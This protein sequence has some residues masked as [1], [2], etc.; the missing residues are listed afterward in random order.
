MTREEETEVLALRFQELRRGELGKA[1][2]V[3]TVVLLFATGTIVPGST[4]PM[5]A[6]RV[7]VLGSMPLA[8][9]L[10]TVID[11]VILGGLAAARREAGPPR[12]P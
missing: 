4:M 1:L 11:L 3:A 5:P 8:F 7:P 9:G 10:A 6:F 12:S 2:E